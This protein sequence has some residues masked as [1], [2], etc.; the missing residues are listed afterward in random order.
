M[1]NVKF[2]CPGCGNNLIVRSPIEI[3]NTN[4]IEGTTCSKCGRTIHKS[5]IVKQARDYAEKAV[6][7]MLGK[8][9]K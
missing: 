5:D 9:F 8:H 4:D 6:R 1:S 3:K 7:D 2:K